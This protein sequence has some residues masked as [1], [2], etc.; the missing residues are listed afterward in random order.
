MFKS[1]FC[2]VNFITSANVV[3]LKWE[4]FCQ[5]EDYRKPLCYVLTLLENNKNSNFIVDARNGF[6]DDKAD[7]TWAFHEF[8][9]QLA[10]AGCKLTCFIVNQDDDIKEE[11]DMF[12]EE[13][14]K[15]VMVEKV[16][17][18]EEAF[19][20][21]SE[22]TGN[23]TVILNV[24]YTIKQGKREEF[25]KKINE[26]GI[27]QKS[28]NEKGNLKYDYYFSADSENQILLI[29]IWK[30]QDSQNAHKELEH[31]KQLQ[32]IKESYVTDVKFEQ[33]INFH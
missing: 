1:E 6:E 19:H 26:A 8:I 30:D 20:K 24:T 3:F 14:M 27:P 21:L 28:R 22:I 13:F 29:E 4:K 15:Y 33:F 9:P 16:L 12:T 2:E 11:I 32:V 31:F 23:N 7:V 5:G 10:K 17:S 18:P 25:Y